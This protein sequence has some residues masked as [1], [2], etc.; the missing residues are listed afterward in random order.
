MKKYL[1]ALAMCRSMFCAIPCFWRVWDEEARDKMLLFL[2]V[3]GL[4]VPLENAV[5]AFR[6]MQAGSLL[7]KAVVH[8]VPA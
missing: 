2:P 8:I 7:G 6:A 1:H 5:Q 3:V 4:E